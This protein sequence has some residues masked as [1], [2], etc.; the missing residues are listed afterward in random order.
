MFFLAQVPFL[1]STI[2]ELTV[3]APTGSQVFPDGPEF[4]RIGESRHASIIV[5]IAESCQ[6]I[7]MQAQR[8]FGVVLR[9]A[10]F[11]PFDGNAQGAEEVEV[12][13]RERAIFAF[14][15]CA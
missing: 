12:V 4:F 5:S 14:V 13:L 8:L 3:R 11:F 1:D 7:P 6:P 10:F 2:H 9:R 15:L